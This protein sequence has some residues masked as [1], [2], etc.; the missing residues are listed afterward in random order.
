MFGVVQRRSGSGFAEET[1]VAFR[2]CV[3]AVTENLD[4]DRTEELCV[5]GAI[6]NPH[7]SF[8]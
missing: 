4:G 3:G 1:P 2:I 8:A 6:D 5:E 7:S